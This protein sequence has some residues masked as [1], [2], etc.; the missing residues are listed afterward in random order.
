MPPSLRIAVADDDRSTREILQTLLTTLGHQVV[1]MAESG[2]SLIDRCAVT[3]PDVLITD[4]LM[5]G[6][7]GLDAAFKIYAS[8]PLPI[9]LL[10][11]YCDPEI[12][13][14]A[15][16]NH[17]V[18]YLVKP[19]SQAHL[20]AALAKCAECL[21][22]LPNK[23]RGEAEEILIESGSRKSDARFPRASTKK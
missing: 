15:E 22:V 7:S 9:V 3:N 10:S 13:R 14:A 21:S 18:V 5:A 11:S 1:V 23:A 2:D 12:V 6:I 16:K 17:V 4:N 20:E 8:R 19:I